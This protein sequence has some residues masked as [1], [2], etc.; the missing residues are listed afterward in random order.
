MTD[1]YETPEELP[2]GWGEA[3]RDL[4][5]RRTAARSMGGAERLAKRHAKGQLDARQRVD[6]LLD[7]GS[8]REIG[9]L[10]GEVPAD[11]IVAGAGT[12]DG[13]PVMIGAEDFT[14][15]AGSI[16]SGS[17]SKRWRIAEL[18]LAERIPLIML[19]EGAGHRG[20]GG[21]GRTP[22]DL[23]IQAQCSGRIPVLSA[24]MGPS[25]GHGAL[26]VP[27]SDFSVMTA[28]GAVFT[29][30]P[31]VV[32]ESLGEDITKEELGGPAVA[33]ASGLI[34]NVAPD[35]TT[36]LDM[37]RVYLHFFPSSA[38]SYPPRAGGADQG[39]RATDEL[40][41]IIPRDTR[42]VY[43]MHEVLDVIVDDGSW[44]EVQPG[45]GPAMICALAHLGG[46]SVAIIAN[47]PKVLAGSIDADA[48]DKA[49]HFITVAD[50]FHLPLVF[51]ADNP[52]ML[53]GSVSERAGVLRSGARMFAAQT[54]ATSPKVHL[55]LRKAYGFGSM[56]MS[57]VGF[58]GQSATFAYPGATLGAMGASA[59]SR[60]TGAEADE[61][62]ELREAELQASYRSAQNLGF[63][64][65]IDPRETRD[66]LLDAVHRAVLRRQAAPEPVLRAAIT[67]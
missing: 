37:L 44:F 40:L 3:L 9:T 34:H 62:A 56:V 41:S 28:D 25:A 65:L 24:V 61:A 51:L 20:G 15:L 4:A 16:G 33:V 64:E 12:I 11:G 23:L 66:V 54:Q 26:I 32:R 18:A 53:P 7:P 8:F 63:D 5:D 39:L 49:A 55:T 27:M 14:T 13:R 67:P 10:V 17:T 2:G 52:G 42:Q 30:G 48:A 46:E 21:G 22:T 50:S 31:P 1:S 43:D 38:W 45:F 36:A 19:L 47:Q 6:H 57:M 59:M 58:D 60:A 29:A 35:D